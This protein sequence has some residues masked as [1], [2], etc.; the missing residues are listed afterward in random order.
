MVMKVSVSE[1]KAKCTHILREVATQP[2]TV[3]ITKRGKVVAVVSQPQQEDGNNP[4]WGALKG[5]V[6]SVSPAF[7]EPLGE[8][9][10]EAAR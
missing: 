1:F 7:D 10:W 3:E 9:E 5:T 8:D 2:Y 4:A 6:L